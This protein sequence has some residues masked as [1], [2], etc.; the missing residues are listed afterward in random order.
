MFLCNQCSQLV[1]SIV[2][3]VYTGAK[4]MDSAKVLATALVSSCLYYCISLLYGIANTDLTKLRCVQNRLV[5]IVTKS[6]PFNCSATLLR[7]LHRLQLK[8]R[9][10]LEISLLTYEM[11][12]EKQPVYLHSML[13]ASLPS[14]SLKSNKE[15]VCQSL[16]LRPTQVQELFTLVSCLSGTTCHCLFVQPFQLLLS[17]NI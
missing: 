5:R 13:A 12:H 11:L 2:P 15:L 6:P 10:L 3:S 17:R 7:S 9:I 14:H 4:V 1:K 16:G 8:F